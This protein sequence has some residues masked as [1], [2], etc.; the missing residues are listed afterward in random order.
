MDKDCVYMD[1]VVHLN[2]NSKLHSAQQSLIKTINFC[3]NICLTTYVESE[4]IFNIS[5]SKFMKKQD[6]HN[7]NLQKNN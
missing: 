3:I 1:V 7:P 4:Q 2:Y 6:Y 5:F